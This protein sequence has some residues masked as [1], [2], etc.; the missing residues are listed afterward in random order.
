MKRVLIN[1]VGGQMGHALTAS[2]REQ[3]EEWEI[4]GGVDPVCHETLPFP[5]FESVEQIDVKPD[6]VI[7]FSVP[8]ATE[9]ILEYCTE[10]HIPIVICTTALPESLIELLIQDHGAETVIAFLENALEVPPIYVRRNPLTCTEAEFRAQIAAE[11]R[12]SPSPWIPTT[13][14]AARSCAAT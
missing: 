3:A 1:G 10:Q 2:L 14:W 6:V 12:S 8:A 4:V 9:R 13:M 11:P 5:V 7:D